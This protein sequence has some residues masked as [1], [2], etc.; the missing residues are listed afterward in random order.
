MVV[1]TKVIS[2]DKV[3]ITIEMK[4][5]EFVAFSSALSCIR[6]GTVIQILDQIPLLSEINR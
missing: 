4:K 1:Q 6:E 2:L 3:R 5:D